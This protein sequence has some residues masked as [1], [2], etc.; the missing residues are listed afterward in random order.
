MKVKYGML[1]DDLHKIS[2]GG[3]FAFCIHA[4]F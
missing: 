4:K 3:A 1:T 2:Q